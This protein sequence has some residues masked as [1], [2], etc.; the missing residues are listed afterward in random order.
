VAP[1]RS[2]A[3]SAHPDGDRLN[4][5]NGDGVNRPGVAEVRERP[6]MNEQWHTAAETGRMRGTHE[7]R[8]LRIYRRW[9]ELSGARSFAVK[10][11]WW[12]ALD[13]ESMGLGL[14][15]MVVALTAPVEASLFD[16]GWTYT[17][18][19]WIGRLP[20][21]V[22]LASL[23]AMWMLG[24]LSF[25]RLVGRRLREAVRPRPWLLVVR[26]LVAGFPGL[27]IGSLPLWRH[28]ANE[29]P[30]W[31][32]RVDLDDERRS[33]GWHP[34]SGRVR[35]L[36]F[37][38]QGALTPWLTGFG[39]LCLAI[40]WL[41]VPG[42]L[43]AS[44]RITLFAVAAA[45]HAVGLTGTVLYVRSLR[46]KGVS[47]V[48]FLFVCFW[49]LPQPLAL[50]GLG[51]VWLDLRLLRGET[52]SWAAYAQHNQAG[53]LTRWSRL[54]G[55]VGRSWRASPW[56]LRWSR[57]AGRRLQMEP[58]STDRA[59]LRLGGAKQSLLLIDGVA[60]GWIAV[61]VGDAEPVPL[62]LGPLVLSLLAAVGGGFL[63]VLGSHLAA[64]LRIVGAPRPLGR[65]RQTWSGAIAVGILDL[66]IAV[67]A[68]LAVGDARNA[69]ITLVYGAT[70]AMVVLAF[71]M[72][73]QVPLVVGGVRGFD[74]ALSWVGVFMGLMVVGGLVAAVPVA[75]SILVGLA[76][77]T[78]LWHG[79]FYRTARSHLG[80][81]LG[82]A[83]PAEGGSSTE[84]P[85]LAARVIMAVPFGGLA[86]PWWLRLRDRQVYGAPDADWAAGWEAE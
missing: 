5:S 70:F 69:G 29:R 3:V 45:L 32:Y 71:G 61:I 2:D 30:T 11:S 85:L 47:W 78:P 77:M 17:G 51:P 39:A 60:A 56:W 79:V 58:T 21:S 83:L 73:L 80:R 76:L 9:S 7:T 4:H 1:G 37:A 35:V 15:A 57:P 64:A 38:G 18:V 44:R 74:L 55:T 23:L 72:V 26:P 36:L 50:G 40:L 33:I 10:R 43:G 13:G 41:S 19:R 6:R 66:G 52:L 62:W 24:A 42:T 20:G 48:S 81:C 59:L 54:E 8:L 14:A 31:A 82:Q 65:L 46:R 53:R 84:G 34:G 86:V 49:L 75:A 27:G 12:G 25:G 63:I 22:V 28:L 16:F 67:G 68:T